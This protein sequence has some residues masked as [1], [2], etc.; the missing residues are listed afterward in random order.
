MSLPP[1]LL[2]ALQGAGL[3]PDLSGLLTDVAKACVPF[4]TGAVVWAGKNLKAISDRVARL[5]TILVGVDGDNGLRGDVKSLREWRHGQNNV[6]QEH[7]AA[8]ELHEFRLNELDRRSE[9]RR[10]ADRAVGQ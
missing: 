5:E 1:L 8:L 4:L 10:A 9:T 3:S 6:V 7:G 2:A